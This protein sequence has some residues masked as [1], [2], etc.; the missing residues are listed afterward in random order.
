MSLG[1]HVFYIV[2]SYAAAALVLG[3]LTVWVWLDYRAQNRALQALDQQGV[4]RRSG[5]SA[6]ENAR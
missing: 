1:P 3:A 5:Q 6:L 2:T 4:S